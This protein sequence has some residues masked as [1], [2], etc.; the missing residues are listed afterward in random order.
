M[1]ASVAT[2]ASAA[3]MLT[4]SAVAL[5]VSWGSMMVAVGGSLGIQQARSTI[6]TSGLSLSKSESIT[7]PKILY[8]TFD[9]ATSKAADSIAE[10]KVLQ[11]KEDIA[12]QARIR[13]VERSLRRV[14]EG[15][16]SITDLGEQLVQYQ[17]A[18]INLMRSEP[19][20]ALRY[21]P[22]Q[23]ML[24]SFGET[25]ENC[26]PK[27]THET[28][29]ML[30]VHADDFE[31]E[32]SKTEYSI[33]TEFG[34]KLILHFTKQDKFMES[35]TKIKIAKG[36]EIN[37]E[38]LVEDYEVLSQPGNPP[39]L[40]PQKTI[41]VEIRPRIIVSG[42]SSAAVGDA[43]LTPEEIRQ[44]VFTSIAQF[45]SQ[46]SYNQLQIVGQ[47]GLSGNTDDVIG[48]VP[49]DITIPKFWCSLGGTEQACEPTN[50]LNCARG[51]GAGCTPRNQNLCQQ[52]EVNGSCVPECS[53]DEL[54][55]KLVA[56]IDPVITFQNNERIIGV[57]PEILYCGW[58]GIANI[59]LA[60]TKIAD[61]PN[62]IPLSFTFAIPRIGKTREENRYYGVRTLAHEMGHNYGNLHATMWACSNTK[63][64]VQSWEGQSPCFYEYGDHF[65]V[66]G[67][68]YL[69]NSNAVLKENLGWLPSQ[70]N[71]HEMLILG[72]TDGG[73]YTLQP[74]GSGGVEAI[75][76][77]RNMQNTDFPNLY[78]EYR[79]P[80]GLDSKL[81][82]FFV[83]QG[84][85]SD[86]FEG[87][88][89][90]LGN[91][92]GQSF[93]ID[94]KPPYTTSLMT[95]LPFGGSYYDPYSGV[96]ITL[97]NDSPGGLPV[98]IVFEDIDNEGPFVS[99]LQ[100]ISSQDCVVVYEAAAQDPSGISKVVFNPALPDLAQEVAG[101]P[102]RWEVNL[103]DYP[104]QYLSFRAY[105]NS[106]LRN[107][108][109]SEKMDLWA[110][111]PLCAHNIK[112]KFY[113]PLENSVQSNTVAFRFDVYSPSGLMQV[114]SDV[115]DGYGQRTRI[116]ENWITE[117]GPSVMERSY[118]VEEN[119]IGGRYRFGLEIINM[120]G[121]TLRFFHYFDVRNACNDGIDNDHDGTIDY[122]G[123]G[124]GGDLGCESVDDN[125]EES[126]FYRSDVDMS[127]GANMTDA[128]IILRHLFFSDPVAL[129]CQ[130][131]ADVD[132][133]GF[134]NITDPI[135]L[136]KYLFA[137]DNPPPPAPYNQCGLDMTSDTIG[138]RSFPSCE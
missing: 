36:Y 124:S 51:D 28:G 95:A 61:D 115:T 57:L 11:L 37:G 130:D 12:R 59:G 66:M 49:M 26:L 78:I 102:Y 17:N 106:L 35:R 46:N 42:G 136:L 64:Q 50:P 119:L 2:T 23:D 75:K 71:N 72:V 114:L 47:D 13:Q 43:F 123:G 135:Y 56:A 15:K 29:S 63:D 20:A 4:V 117:L 9:F 138:C 74:M 126:T 113:S 99:G 68:G 125:S 94:A 116:I 111:E 27:E 5:F 120:E 104:E 103:M 107:Y 21:L 45:Y 70:D 79:R 65:D 34:K 108:S 1:K 41:V 18:F 25:T 81:P 98:T 7:C 14:V 137:T 133:S 86:V 109:D 44:D 24:D 33:K 129:S 83:K 8:R 53:F 52:G 122:G 40:G 128:I 110:D 91:A 10:S 132:D 39:A 96:R 92:M 88:T 87:A 131:A 89:I 97:G 80:E 3:A 62:P 121:R 16:K 22:D 32:T 38:L 82:D 30:V 54:Q 6:P 19:T 76:I 134:V 105:D 84:L 101:P 67:R 90:H 118:H 100:K 77:P 69:P 112:V 73:T 58:T 48:P 55:Q 127:G 31:N 60:D 85:A 93:L